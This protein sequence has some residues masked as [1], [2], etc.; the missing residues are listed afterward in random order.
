MKK[1][2]ELCG[3]SEAAVSYT[4]RG[5]R[6]VNARTRAR[7]LAVAEKHRYRPNALVRSIQSKRSMTVGVACNSFG[8][9][10]S[11]RV[12]NGAVA[13]L[14]VNQYEVFVINW[15]TEVRDGAHVL[16]SLGER[17]VDGVLMYPPYGVDP[18]TY[19]DEM[20]S[21]HTPL[22]LVDQIVAGADCDYVGSDDVPGGEAV[23]EHLMALGHGKIGIISEPTSPRHKGFSKALAHH[24]VPV[25]EQW[26]CGFGTEG[27]MYAAVKRMLTESDRPTA[28][29]CCSD[30]AAIVVYSAAYDLGLQIPR[31]LSVTGYADLIFAREVR[32]RI[33][34]VS[35][36]PET[37]GERAARLLL[38]RI[39]QRR[40]EG[41]DAAV[42]PE[43]ILLPTE[44]LIRESTGRPK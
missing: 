35:Q 44:L 14:S 36:S 38:N 5:K 4:L 27:D 34:T 24:G 3:V 37:I 20:R 28:I 29:A 43:Q 17:R 2:A 18:K 13:V 33:T 23:M 40:E 42:E 32:P 30:T 11:G 16:R 21:F 19:L 9:D 8:F 6:K 7:I 1:I 12:V 31:D 41:P 25:R 15:N 39:Q 26:T 10:F 22:V